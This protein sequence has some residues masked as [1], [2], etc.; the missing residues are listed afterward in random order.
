VPSSLFYKNFKNFKII[1]LW[2]LSFLKRWKKESINSFNQSKFQ[3]SEYD[4]KSQCQK[5]I[6]VRLKFLIFRMD[7]PWWP[8][9]ESTYLHFGT[10]LPFVGH[11]ENFCIAYQDQD[12]ELL[13]ICFDKKKS[14]LTIDQIMDLLKLALLFLVWK[15]RNVF[16]RTT[17][18]S[19]FFLLYISK[20]NVDFAELQQP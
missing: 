19:I 11:F 10:K 13:K 5:Y 4:V 9:Q 15:M 20:Q 2:L 7:L 6:K 17:S 8:I 14:P 12:F 16:T 1:F 3:N 18:A